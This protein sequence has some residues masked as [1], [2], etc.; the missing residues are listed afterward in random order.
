MVIVPP[1]RFR[2]ILV[3]KKHRLPE[4]D[5]GKLL[6][7]QTR[8]QLNKQIFSRS[9]TLVIQFLTDCRHVPRSVR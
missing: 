3:A 5:L 8:R 6:F 9:G 1:L 7:G 4:T 2:P